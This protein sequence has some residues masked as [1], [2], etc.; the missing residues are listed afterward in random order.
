L[1]KIRQ[2]DR[3]SIR[4]FRRPVK[5]KE[6]ATRGEREQRSDYRRDKPAPM[7]CRARLCFPP[8]AF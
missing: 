7:F 3:V 1:F 5:D 2:D 6:Q 8:Q 4:K